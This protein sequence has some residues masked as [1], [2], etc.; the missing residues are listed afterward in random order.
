MN[1]LT[2]TAKTSAT[3][4]KITIVPESLGPSTPGA[5]TGPAG[6]LSVRVNCCGIQS[7][8]QRD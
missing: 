5:V 6:G 3:V 7:W 1:R 8:N 4:D 2:A